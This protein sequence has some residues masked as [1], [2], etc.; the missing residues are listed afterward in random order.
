MCPYTTFLWKALCE[1]DVTFHVT[2]VPHQCEAMHDLNMSKCDFVST[3]ANCQEEAGLINYLH[4]VYCTM[5]P[6]LIPLSMVILVSEGQTQWANRVWTFINNYIAVLCIL[7]LMIRDLTRMKISPYYHS[8]PMV[9]GPVCV[10]GN[11]IR[12]LVS[13]VVAC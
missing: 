4:F 13:I 1:C 8:V 6:R 7:W 12:K 5:P 3:V 11:N 2:L 9:S 10:P